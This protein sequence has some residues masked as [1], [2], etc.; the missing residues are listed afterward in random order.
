MKKNIFKI[1]ILLLLLAEQPNLQAQKP[2]SDYLQNLINEDKQGK[3]NSTF[4]LTIGKLETLI[5]SGTKLK[6]L[7]TQFG[8]WTSYGSDNKLGFEWDD[9]TQDHTIPLFQIQYQTTIKN[10]YYTIGTEVI[11]DLKNKIKYLEVTTEL[12]G[13]QLAEFKKSLATN[14]Y[15]INENLTSIF[16]KQTWQNKAKNLM[17]TIKANSRSYTIGIR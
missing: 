14:G 2:S 1:A 13:M 11:N 9:K 15:L 10:K 7:E 3:G 16:R 12:N 5:K 8:E 4:S 17:V 6:E